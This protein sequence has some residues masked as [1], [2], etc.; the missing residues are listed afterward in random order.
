MSGSI[1]CRS[2]L[3]A[4]KSTPD[5]DLSDRL[6]DADT[7]QILSPSDFLQTVAASRVESNFGCGAV[8]ES[9]VRIHRLLSGQRPAIS[10]SW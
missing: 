8:E 2:K 7:T 5:N 10:M 6:L 3:L 4:S 9:C 1:W